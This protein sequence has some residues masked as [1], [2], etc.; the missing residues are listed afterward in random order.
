MPLPVGYSLLS[1]QHWPAAQPG[2]CQGSSTCTRIS[3]SQSS[4]TSTGTG[5]RKGTCSGTG[6]DTTG[7]AARPC[8]ACCST[9]AGMEA[10]LLRNCRTAF[11]PRAA[12]L[13]LGLECRAWGSGLSLG[14]DRCQ[15]WAL[16][17]CC[18]VGL[19]YPCH[20]MCMST[21]QGRREEFG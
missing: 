13:L 14:L 17:C 6:G 15:W 19:C 16:R 9:A 18:R 11:R 1:H 4:G 10:L 20:V 3:R 5:S 2:R 8:N 12:S 21:S 7:K